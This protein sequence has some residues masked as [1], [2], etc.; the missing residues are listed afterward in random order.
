MQ[1]SL[2]MVSQQEFEDKKCNENS[3]TFKHV[4]LNFLGG[5]PTSIC[6]SFRRIFYVNKGGCENLKA[7]MYS[8][9]MDLNKWQCDLGHPDKWE[10][11]T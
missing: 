1:H 11:P 5:V 9:N 7:K 3:F 10:D 6:P 8:P 4:V 2:V